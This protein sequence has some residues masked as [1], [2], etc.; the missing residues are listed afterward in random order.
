M[1]DSVITKLKIH[2]SIKSVEDIRRVIPGW[3]WVD[4]YGA[5]VSQLEPIDQAWLD[6]C[7]R[8]RADKATQKRVRREEE[9]AVKSQH[10]TQSSSS[11]IV[12][13]PA[14]QQVPFDPLHGAIYAQYPVVTFVAKM[15]PASRSNCYIGSRPAHEEEVVR[16][17]E[18]YKNNGIHVCVPGRHLAAKAQDYVRKGTSPGKLQELIAWSGSRNIDHTTVED[19]DEDN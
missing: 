14:F 7:A 6:A 13:A 15:V 3:A 1:P 9:R 12:P 2:A 5:E 4:V 11:N 10:S 19:W 17:R 16:L 18:A 8:K